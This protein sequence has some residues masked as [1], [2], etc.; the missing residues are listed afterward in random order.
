MVNIT[1]SRRKEVCQWFCPLNGHFLTQRRE[2]TAA[3]LHFGADSSMLNVNRQSKP[4][5]R[6]A[7]QRSPA[8]AAKC[9]CKY[10]GDRIKILLT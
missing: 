2:T 4:E 7:F 10:L 3:V 1:W 5:M 9:I 6:F 8:E